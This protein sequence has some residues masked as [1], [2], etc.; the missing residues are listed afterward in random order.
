MSLFSL[1]ILFSLGSAF[2]GALTSLLARQ[3][4]SVVSTRDFLT[5][6]FSLLFI[7]LLPFAPFGFQISWNV[8]TI[9]LIALAATIDTLGNYLF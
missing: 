6:N 2:F 3:I 7:T 1:S 4:M 8:K 5:I 9:L